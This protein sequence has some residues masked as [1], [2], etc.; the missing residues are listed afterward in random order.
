MFACLRRAFIIAHRHV[1]QIAS[2]PVYEGVEKMRAPRWHLSVRLLLPRTD[3]DMQRCV[4]AQ[5]YK[6]APMGVHP[7]NCLLRSAATPT[8]ELVWTSYVY[9][10]NPQGMRDTNSAAL[11]YMYWVLPAT[12]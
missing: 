12:R 10:L 4:V 1:E 3:G 8:L 7:T 6:V 2:P 11:L 9:S 5:S